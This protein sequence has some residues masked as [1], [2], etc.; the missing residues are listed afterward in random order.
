MQLTSVSSHASHKCFSCKCD[1]HPDSVW[2]K[3]VI[4]G[5]LK[6]NGYLCETCSLDETIAA[7]DMMATNNSR[8]ISKDD[9]YVIRTM[10]RWAV[11]YR[12]YAQQATSREMRLCWSE[13]RKAYLCC[14]KMVAEKYF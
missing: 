11:S 12:K 1:V 10:V 9:L 14:A 4:N 7:P 6:T 2:Y 5:K 13:N 8:D 3:L